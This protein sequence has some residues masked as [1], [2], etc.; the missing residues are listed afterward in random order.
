MG[1]KDQGDTS[2]IN[3][4]TCHESLPDDRMYPINPITHENAAAN[5]N[6]TTMPRTGILP[7]CTGP[8]TREPVSIWRLTRTET[9]MTVKVVKACGDVR[10]TRTF[11]GR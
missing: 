5:P 2:A 9:R 1:V 8:W 4:F 11:A 3:S 6:N 10:P 7:H